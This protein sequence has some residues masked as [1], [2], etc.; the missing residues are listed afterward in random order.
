[1]FSKAG[2]LYSIAQVS[3]CDR[4]I[5]VLHW[6]SD[7]NVKKWKSISKYFLE[8]HSK[9]ICYHLHSFMSKF[10]LQTL[11][12]AKIVECRI[13]L[14]HTE[15]SPT[16]LMNNAT[17]SSDYCLILSAIQDMPL[18]DYLRTPCEEFG[19]KTWYKNNK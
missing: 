16:W 1:M 8:I 9:I 10:C 19:S 3:F 13:T 2:K 12:G 18:W 6:S 7:V 15:E 11:Q 14:N 4:D 5:T 17:M